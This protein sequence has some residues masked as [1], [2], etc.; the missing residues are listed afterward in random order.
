MQESSAGARASPSAADH[1]HVAICQA[2]ELL[3][4]VDDVPALQDE[5]VRCHVFPLSAIAPAWRP[6]G[7][8]ARGSLVGEASWGWA[9]RSNFS[10]TV[11]YRFTA[12]EQSVVRR[13]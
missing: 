1:Q 10:T 5:I 12:S 6:V 3:R 9:L 2:I 4:R 13:C 11:S 8:V 7:P